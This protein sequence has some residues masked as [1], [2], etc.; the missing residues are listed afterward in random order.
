[1]TLCA[2]GGDTAP[3]IYVD[4]R[5]CQL[6]ATAQVVE[7]AHDWLPVTDEIVGVVLRIDSA[8]ASLRPALRDRLRIVS[9]LNHRAKH[10]IWQF[11]K[12]PA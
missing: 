3:L 11:V 8:K 12:G 4:G 5:T 2:S 9:R 1:M 6:R 7:S 10:E